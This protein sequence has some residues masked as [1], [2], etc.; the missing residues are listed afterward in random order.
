MAAFR[1]DRSPAA[2][3][4]R[5]RRNRTDQVRAHM[6]RAVTRLAEC[7]PRFLSYLGLSMWATLRNRWCFGFAPC[8]HIPRNLP[9]PPQAAGRYRFSFFGAAPSGEVTT[10]LEDMGFGLPWCRP[11]SRCRGRDLC[12]GWRV[13]DRSGRKSAEL[14]P[15]TPQYAAARSVASTPD[16]C[17]SRATMSNARKP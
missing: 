13:S 2:A 1:D 17:K 4:T 10:A 8:R 16:G 15:Y 5:R 6:P 7:F 3:A 14:K 9:D 12:G 11:R